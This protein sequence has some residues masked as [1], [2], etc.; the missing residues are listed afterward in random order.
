MKK[1]ITVIIINNSLLSVICNEF[2]LPAFAVKIVFILQTICKP[3]ISS[4]PFFSNIFDFR[5]LKMLPH[6]NQDEIQVLMKSTA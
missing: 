5:I 3:D 1:A 2:T 6:H 4:K